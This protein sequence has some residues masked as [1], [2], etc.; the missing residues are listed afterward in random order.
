MKFAKRVPRG[1]AVMLVSLAAGLGVAACGSGSNATS[2]KNASSTSTT[3]SSGRT[4]FEACLK[5]HGVSL[6][7]GAAGGLPGGGGGAPPSGSNG[8]FTPP[9]GGANGAP[10]SGGL[11]G[12]GGQGFAGGGNSKFSKAIRACGSKLGKSGFGGG[13]AGGNAPSGGPGAKT[14]FSQA[15]LKSFVACV[16]RNGYAG[17]PE[18]NSDGKFPKSVETDSKF[19]RAARKCYSIL[20][21]A[22]AGTSTTSTT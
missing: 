7:K 14:H 4:A 1:A 6:P 19:Q 15:T 20:F 8:N 18:A 2:G 17:M 9:T 13:F 10:P 11:P 12:G 5:Q 21:H 16:R 22:P 3:K